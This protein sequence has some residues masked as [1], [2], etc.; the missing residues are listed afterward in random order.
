MYYHLLSKR[1][2]IKKYASKM[3]LVVL[4]VRNLVSRPKGRQG[5]SAWLIKKIGEAVTF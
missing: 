5:K 3:S 1:F 4:Y 2:K